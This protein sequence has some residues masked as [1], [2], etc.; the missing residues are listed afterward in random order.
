MTIN[1]NGLIPLR[2]FYLFEK[3]LNNISDLI[4]YQQDVGLLD[5]KSHNLFPP[6]IFTKLLLY[7]VFI[8]FVRDVLYSALF[9][10]S[11]SEIPIKIYSQFEFNFFKRSIV[12]SWYHITSYIMDLIWS[13]QFHIITHP[14]IDL[15]IY[16]LTYLI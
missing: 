9:W 15:I 14:M 13:K 2:S 6:F 1:K 11:E 10:L 4:F 5:T 3:S 12:M 16:H 7:N 8:S